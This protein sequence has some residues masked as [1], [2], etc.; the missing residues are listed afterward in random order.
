MP[1]WHCLARVVFPDWRE[2]LMSTAGASL[3][4]ALKG[5]EDAEES[6]P[7]RPGGLHTCFEKDVQNAV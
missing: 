5:A 2:P 6:I 1:G 7:G 3:K 4:A